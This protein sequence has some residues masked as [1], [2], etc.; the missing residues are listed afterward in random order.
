MLSPALV[1][2]LGRLLGMRDGGGGRDPLSL[3]ARFVRNSR[4]YSAEGD[5]RKLF[6]FFSSASK[7][8]NGLMGGIMSFVRSGIDTTW[9]CLRGEDFLGECGSL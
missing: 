8:I 5:S 2:G 9:H 7:I 3:A 6:F 4:R 1:D